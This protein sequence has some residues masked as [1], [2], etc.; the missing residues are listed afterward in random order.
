[1]LIN[2]FEWMKRALTGR[3]VRQSENLWTKLASHEYVCSGCGETHRGIP[4][5]A[6]GK[7]EQWPGDENKQPNSTVRTS[8]NALTE[9]FCILD[10]KHFF[11][12][13]ILY[14][15][16]K[17]FEKEKFGFGV[18]TTLSKENFDIY[19]EN[20]DRNDQG[21]FGPWFGWFSNRLKGYPDT[22][23]LK[24]QVYPQF[25]RLRPLIELGA[26]DHPL[27]LEQKEGVSINRI[28]ELLSMNGHDI[29]YIEAN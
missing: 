27:A 29:G 14:L 6:C 17:E 8:K 2:S 22:L 12:R 9:D 16:I 28:F 5:L 19:C 1:V 23:N 7:P 18:W 20:F 25:E 24:C 11:V 26:T 21:D 3:T 10:G 13:A 4:E 15:P